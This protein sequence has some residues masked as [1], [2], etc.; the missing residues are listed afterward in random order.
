MPA[1]ISLKMVRGYLAN[2]VCTLHNTGCVLWCALCKG[3]VPGAQGDAKHT[4]L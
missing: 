4:S 3:D 1:S 2:V